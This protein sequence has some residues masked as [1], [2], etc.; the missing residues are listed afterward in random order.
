MKVSEF[1]E[2]LSKVDQDKEITFFSTADYWTEPFIEVG[3]IIG[4]RNGDEVNKAWRNMTKAERYILNYEV[5]GKDE[6]R[7][8]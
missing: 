1:V 3:D 2:L 7:I 5:G 6:G 8:G 4:V